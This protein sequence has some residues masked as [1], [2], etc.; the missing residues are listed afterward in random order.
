MHWSSSS[1]E[2]TR[3]GEIIIQYTILHILPVHFQMPAPVIVILKIKVKNI[4]SN[5]GFQR[6]RTN[7]SVIRWPCKKKKKNTL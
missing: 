4:A 3:N 2:N 5:G 6:A 7:D 1:T